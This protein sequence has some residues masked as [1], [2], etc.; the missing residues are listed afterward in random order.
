MIQSRRISG[1]L[2]APERMIVVGPLRKRGEVGDL[3]D[4]EILQLLVEVAEARRGDAIGANAEID[5]V[6]IQLEDLVL[7]VGTLDAD[8]EDSLL[9][10]ALHR[11]LAAEQEVL[12]DLL[13]DRRA[14]L[15]TPVVTLDLGLDDF[16]DGTRDALEVD[17]AML[18]EAAVLG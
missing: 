16:E 15:G 5:L 14:T 4:R 1:L 18:V 9:E 6:E 7:R 8:G 10:L 11:A 17:A 12:G 3:L 2:L 13:G